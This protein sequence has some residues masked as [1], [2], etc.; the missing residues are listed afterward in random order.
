MGLCLFA[1]TV[2]AVAVVGAAVIV[3][4]SLRGVGGW[5]CWGLA[6]STL[7]LSVLS[8]EWLPVLTPVLFPVLCWVLL[9]V[10]LPVSLLLLLL[11]VSLLL[12]QLLLV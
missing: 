9:P 1:A 4:S 10:L 12:K 5:G 11:L 2:A 3:K 7:F 8:P 6:P